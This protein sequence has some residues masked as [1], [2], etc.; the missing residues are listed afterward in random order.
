M[1]RRRLAQ[2]KAE[3][4]PSSSATFFS[5]FLLPF[6]PLAAVRRCECEALLADHRPAHLLCPLPTPFPLAGPAFFRYTDSAPLN[7]SLALHQ[8]PYPV[9]G[10]RHGQVKK[11][12]IELTA[13]GGGA[14][15]ARK[16]KIDKRNEVLRKQ[17]G[18]GGLDGEE[19]KK[20][21]WAAEAE[22]KAIEKGK[23]KRGG[24]GKV[25]PAAAADKATFGAAEAK[26]ATGWGED[27]ASERAA[28]RSKS[29]G[30]GGGGGAA[31][32]AG[33]GGRG[34][35]GAAGRGRGGG[36]GGAV[37]GG[38]RRGGATWTPGTG[39]NFTALG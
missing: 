37:A 8:T 23:R 38:D 15:A 1:R 20:A 26:V 5:L 21:R 19:E 7:A 4:S 16:T 12:N 10:A 22:A 39:A 32:V 35:G 18:M 33:R 11:L 3:A 36:R 29:G 28:K 27:G 13:G 17:A 2:E 6:E 34:G 24:G 14:G 9:P 30:G 25:D 31:A